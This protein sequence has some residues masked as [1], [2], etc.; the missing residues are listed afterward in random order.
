MPSRFCIHYVSKSGRPSSGHRTGKSQSLSQLPRR[1]PPK[2][3]LAIRQLHSSSLLVR[4]CLKFFPDVQ[5]GFRKGRRTRNQIANICWIIEKTREFQKKI[6]ISVSSTTLKPL[7][8]WIMTNCG[9]L[10]ERWKCQTILSVSWEPVC[11]S[12]SN[13]EN[14]VWNNWLF[15][16]REMSTTGLSAV[17]LFV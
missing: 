16:D 15:Q 4:S 7:T 2:N 5:A 6:S 8:V 17:T 1:V 14:P 9:R 13:S 3:V 11:G 10:L 12:R